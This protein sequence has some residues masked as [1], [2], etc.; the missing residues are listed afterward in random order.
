MRGVS[1][2]SWGY[3]YFRAGDACANWS[4]RIG[5]DFGDYEECDNTHRW[6]RGI[7]GMSPETG[8][9]GAGRRTACQAGM[10]TWPGTMCANRKEWLGCE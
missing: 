4:C 9:A 6:G 7:T 10:G 3:V 2:A 5:G 1:E 8:K